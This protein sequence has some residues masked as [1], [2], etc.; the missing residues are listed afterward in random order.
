MTDIQL[1]LQLNNYKIKSSFS[2]PPRPEEPFLSP[3]TFQSQPR[4]FPSAHWYTSPH[5][6]KISA[7]RHVHPSTVVPS[8]LTTLALLTVL[9][10][11][12][13]L[14]ALLAYSSP[15]PSPA[16]FYNAQTIMDSGDNAS[17]VVIADSA[18]ALLNHSVPPP[19]LISIHTGENTP[20]PQNRENLSDSL[21][22]IVDSENGARNFR[23]R[24]RG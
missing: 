22:S 20:S 3:H 9:I 21:H 15:V 14:T 4:F 5:I 13:T 18:T 16:T 6:L 19:G 12:F 2:G 1:Q 24:W 8:S 10:L 7:Q 23:V 17:V 11:A